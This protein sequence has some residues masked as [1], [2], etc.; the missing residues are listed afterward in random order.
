M[1]KDQKFEAS[2]GYIVSWRPVG[3]NEIVLEVRKVE[4]KGLRC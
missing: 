2:L 3:Y 4:S 1:Q